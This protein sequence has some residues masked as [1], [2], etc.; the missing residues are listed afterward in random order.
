MT[1]GSLIDVDTIGGP[2]LDG[3]RND[4]RFPQFK[5]ISD[6]LMAQVGKVYAGELEARNL[7]MGRYIGVLDSSM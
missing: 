1:F 7:R 5:Q 6:D 3:G 2:P 4:P